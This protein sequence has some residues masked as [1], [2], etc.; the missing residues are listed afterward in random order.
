[1]RVSVIIPAYNAA[2]FIGRNLASLPEGEARII[3]VDDGSQDETAAEVRRV[4]PSA[5]LL[6]QKNAGVS[7]ARNAGMDVSDAD[8]FVF[9]DADDRLAPGAL[10]KLTSFLDVT[11][12]DCV[13]MRSF[14]DGVERYPW[15][16]L[17][18]EGVLL[19]KEAI[20]RQG[21]IRG[22]V[23]GCAF[24]KDYVLEHHLRF[25]EGIAMGEDC[26]FLS[27]ALSA[28]GHVMFLDIPFYQVIEH[29]G[30]ASRQLSPGF[31]ARYAA[32]LVTASRQ[33]SDSA[34]R[35]YTCLSF[36]L[37]ITRVGRKLGYGPRKTF[38][39]GRFAEV[40]PLSFEGLQKKRETVR[41]MNRAYPVLYYVQGLKDRLVLPSFRKGLWEK[42]LVARFVKG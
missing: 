13:I 29:A 14:C 10:E 35:S 36:M 41:M 31:L 16:G 30:S 12:P 20:I 23:C 4:R 34:L 38:A 18:K 11:H 8:Y 2:P 42:G 15:K 21:Y 22:S 9:M 24:R 5:L 26:V 27:M 32:G 39:E 7:A 40:L 17:F 19:T 1:M 6:R 3:V 33:I 25:P 37:G 28:G